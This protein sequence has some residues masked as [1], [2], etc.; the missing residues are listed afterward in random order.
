MLTWTNCLKLQRNRI[1]YFLLGQPLWF[2]CVIRKIILLLHLNLLTTLLQHL[3]IQ[4]FV[5]RIQTYVP[6]KRQPHKIVRH[7]QV[8]RRQ[9][10]T[11]CL[12][13]YENFVGLAL[14]GLSECSVN[15]MNAVWSPKALLVSR[16]YSGEQG[17]PKYPYYP[18]FFLRK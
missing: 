14:N 3:I 12:S 7:T 6:F 16:T 1:I 2:C 4:I 11:K 13:V 15:I 17:W 9:Q 10:P 8:I 5:W 18:L